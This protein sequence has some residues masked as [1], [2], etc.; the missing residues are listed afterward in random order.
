MVVIAQ[1]RGNKDSSG[2][3]AVR[4]D[5]SWSQIRNYFSAFREIGMWDVDGKH[6][7][8]RHRNLSVLH[9]SCHDYIHMGSKS[10]AGA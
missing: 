2:F 7:N 1:P 9:K 5:F 4:I 6:S 3:R 8:W 10:K